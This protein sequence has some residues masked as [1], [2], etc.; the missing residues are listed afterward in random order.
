ML[1]VVCFRVKPVGKPDAVAPHVRFDEQGWETESWQA[2]LRRCH[3]RDASS[4]RKPKATAPVL[5]ST[6]GSL[7]EKMKA[8]KSVYLPWIICNLISRIDAWFFPYIGPRLSIVQK[9]LRYHFE[10][11]DFNRVES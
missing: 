10:T 6:G 11:F 1:H 9:R 2:G 8:Q 4:H 3:E 7:A 5:D